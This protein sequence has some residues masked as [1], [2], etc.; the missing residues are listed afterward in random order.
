MRVQPIEILTLVKDVVSTERFIT[1]KD[2][3][4][5]KQLWPISEY[6]HNIRLDGLRRNEYFDLHSSFYKEIRT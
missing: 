5:G 3:G 2:T 1:S 6:Y 4:S